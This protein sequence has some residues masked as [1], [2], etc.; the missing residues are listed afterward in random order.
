MIGRFR[1]GRKLS[2]NALRHIFHNVS[3]VYKTESEAVTAV[4]E[5]FTDASK[6]LVVERFISLTSL[7]TNGKL[8]KRPRKAK[9]AFMKDLSARYNL[10][11]ILLNGWDNYKNQI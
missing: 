6:E 11:L 9:K 1:N 3:K 5:G 4:T 7:V 8:D 10:Y 2:N